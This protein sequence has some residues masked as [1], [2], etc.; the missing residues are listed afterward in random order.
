MTPSELSAALRKIASKIDA[1]KNP[2]RELVIS[3]IQR[4][5]SRLVTAAWEPHKAKNVE[6]VDWETAFKGLVKRG[7]SAER[8]M[9]RHVLKFL[10]D[11][12]PEKYSL[13]KQ[14]PLMTDIYYEIK[15]GKITLKGLKADTAMLKKGEPPEED[16]VAMSASIPV[17]DYVKQN[18]KRIE[19]LTK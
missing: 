18:K 12:Q 11:E 8:D 1:S 9:A 17:K 4:V 6:E 7:I 13:Q 16:A 15:D 10:E 2:S 5:A 3:D 19:E 14:G